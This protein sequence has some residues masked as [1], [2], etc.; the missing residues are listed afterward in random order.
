MSESE[1]ALDE[2]KLSLNV[3][4]SVSMTNDNPTELEKVVSETP[5]ATKEPSMEEAFADEGIVAQK[6]VENGVT[7]T[8]S[9]NH[10]VEE[11]AAKGTFIDEGIVTQSIGDDISAT[12]QEVKDSELKIGAPTKEASELDNMSL[13]SSYSNKQRARDDTELNTSRTQAKGQNETDSYSIGSRSK[14]SV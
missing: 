4:E 10:V 1:P 7:E 8:P 14:Y 6:T 12:S 11:P 2:E 5:T 3:T 13:S 9:T